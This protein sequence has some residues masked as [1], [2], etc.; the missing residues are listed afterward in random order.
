MCNKENSIECPVCHIKVKNLIRHIRGKHDRSLSNREAIEKAFPELIGCKLQ[1]TSFDTSREYKCEFCEKV[2]HRL[3]D[4][5]NHIRN[6]HPEHYHKIEHKKKLPTIACP[7]CNKESGNLRQHVGDS[8]G[9]SWEDFCKEYNWDPTKVKVITDEYRQLLSNNKKQ[10]YN[11]DAG[12]E[13]RKLQSK[14]WSDNNPSKDREKISRAINN[15]AIHESQ[16][17]ES[18]SC[19]GIKV[20]YNERSFRSFCEFEFYMLCKMH[21][22]DAEYE[23][24]KYCVKWFNKEKN[25]YTTYLPDFYIDRIGLI[26]LKCTDRDVRIAK[27]SDKYVAVGSV[28]KELAIEYN[29]TTPAKFFNKSGIEITIEDRVALK[30]HILDL[31]NKGEIKFTV[32]SKHS[33]VMKNIFD[34]DDLSTISCI[35]IT[36]K[37]R[38][39]NEFQKD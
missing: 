26:E 32:P 5:Q 19:Y 31:A 1:I 23:P 38:Y 30:K 29:I 4:I 35:T 17:I 16:P 11:S 27:E 2:Y 8:H 21:N 12:I 18:N 36:H 24:G 33:R 20:H 15:R 22:I 34:V 28:Y 9:L 10:Y 13:R 14:V 37:S 39:D 6:H 25:F 7:I 3:N